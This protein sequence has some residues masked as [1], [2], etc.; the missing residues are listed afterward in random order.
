[1]DREKTRREEASIDATIELARVA[2]RECRQYQSA[3]Y[4]ASDVNADGTIDLSDYKGDWDH[5]GK[6]FDPRDKAHGA[7]TEGR[8]AEWGPAAQE[9]MTRY[10]LKPARPFDNLCKGTSVD[11]TP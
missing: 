10:F 5:D 3:L 4:P 9:F 8:V 1:L 2:G 11:T 6:D 7:F